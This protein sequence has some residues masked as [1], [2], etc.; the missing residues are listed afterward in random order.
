MDERYG[1]GFASNESHQSHHP[2]PGTDAGYP[3]NSDNRLDSFGRRDEYGSSS[4][5]PDNR[6]IRNDNSSGFGSNGRGGGGADFGSSWSG[7]GHGA[8]STA[9]T[10]SHYTASFGS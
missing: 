10:R 9:G 1:A 8:D 3:R 6:G 5:R 7:F 4:Y 2:F